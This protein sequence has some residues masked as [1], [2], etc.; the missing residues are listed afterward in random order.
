MTPL[1]AFAGRDSCGRAETWLASLCVSRL[2]HGWSLAEAWPMGAI[3]ADIILGRLEVAGWII[4][5]KKETWYAKEITFFGVEQMNGGSAPCLFT[6]MP[7]DKL[8]LFVSGASIGE[9]G[10]K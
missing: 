2:R 6:W 4:R 1:K 7:S 10:N 3:D 5:G 8:L 9:R